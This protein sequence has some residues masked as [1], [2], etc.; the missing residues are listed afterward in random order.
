[1]YCEMHCKTAH[2]C[3]GSATDSCLTVE[4]QK[5]FS[6]LLAAQEQILNLVKRFK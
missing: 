4:G 1:M 2:E 5:G 3:N 6:E